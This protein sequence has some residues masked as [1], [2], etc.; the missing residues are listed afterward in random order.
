MSDFDDDIKMARAAMQIAV[1]EIP[2]EDREQRIALLFAIT[3]QEGGVRVLE[4]LKAELL[5]ILHT[6]LSR[7]T[8]TRQ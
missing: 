2:I 4:A 6:P 7:G 8:E 1:D 5:P 3:R